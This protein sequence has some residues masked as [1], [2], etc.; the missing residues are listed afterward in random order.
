MRLYTWIKLCLNFR[1]MRAKIKIGCEKGS[2]CYPHLEDE[3]LKHSKKKKEI[4]IFY[5]V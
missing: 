3:K 2:I 1:H 5:R 4:L